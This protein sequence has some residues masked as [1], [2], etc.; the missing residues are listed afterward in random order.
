[1]SCLFHRFSKIEYKRAHLLC[2]D[3][4][5]PFA[6]RNS[7]VEKKQSSLVRSNPKIQR[8]YL[9]PAAMSVTNLN[10][11]S[12]LAPEKEMLEEHQG[13]PKTL[14]EII[15]ISVSNHSPPIFSPKRV[16]FHKKSGPSNERKKT[17]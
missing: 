6:H 11:I 17:K 8:G 5:P 4:P 1:M 16:S 7:L 10:K 9:L 14:E 2:F 3:F 12:G 15:N 13:P